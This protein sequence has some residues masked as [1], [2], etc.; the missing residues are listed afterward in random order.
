MKKLDKR[1]LKKLNRYWTK[2][3]KYF[4]NYISLLDTTT[5]FDMY[6]I[7]TDWEG[8]GNKNSTNR[9]NSIHLAYK[10]LQYLEEFTL[11]YPKEI[12]TWIFIHENSYEDAVNLHTQNDNKSPYTY[13]FEGNN[14]NWN[15]TDNTNIYKIGKMVNQYGSIYV[16][17][18]L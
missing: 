18:K 15:I 3:G 13:S 6:H 14:T 4:I 7:H 10:A 5:W 2:M 9:K 1:Y 16:V 17:T 12:Q 11:K 8:K